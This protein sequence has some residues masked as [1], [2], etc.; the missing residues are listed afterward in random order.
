MDGRDDKW[1]QKS[2]TLKERNLFKNLEVDELEVITKTGLK[3]YV[4]AALPLV[5]NQ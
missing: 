2:G 1:I 3:K 4:L 5:M